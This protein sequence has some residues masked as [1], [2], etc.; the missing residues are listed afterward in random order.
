VGRMERVKNNGNSIKVVKIILLL[1]VI[2]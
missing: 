1:K 2:K